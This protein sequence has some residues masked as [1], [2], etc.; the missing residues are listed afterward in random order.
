MILSLLLVVV[1]VYKHIYVYICVGA[2]DAGRPWG[3]EQVALPGRSPPPNDKT[4]KLYKKSMANLWESMAL[5]WTTYHLSWP[6]LEAGDLPRYVPKDCHFS[7]GFSLESSNGCSAAFSSGIS[8]LRC[9]VCNLLP[10]RWRCPGDPLVYK[11]GGKRDLEIQV[12]SPDQLSEAFSFDFT[13]T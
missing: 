3:R 5:L 7:V 6:R 13:H 1:V 4:D 11:S 10:R 8:L 9:L 2:S 12:S